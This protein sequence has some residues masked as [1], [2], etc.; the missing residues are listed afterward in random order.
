MS[1][2]ADVDCVRSQVVGDQYG[3][4]Y[5][6]GD[7]EPRLTSFAKAIAGGGVMPDSCFV[8]GVPAP[9]VA[10]TVT[11]S[12]GT[13]AALVRGYVETF[14]TQWGEEGAPS[15]VQLVNGKV[16][17]TT[18]AL[19]ALNPAPINTST[20]SAASHAAGVVT[21]TTAST[22][23]LRAGEEVTHAGIVGMTDLN[24]SFI[25][26]EVVDSAHYK[27]LLN[28]TQTY[29]SGG[30][31]TRVAPHNISN[32]TRRIY[33]TLNGKYYFVTELPIS[34]A[35]YND[36]V[37]DAALQE[38]LPSLG[39]E[40]PPPTMKALISLPNGCNAAI[41]GY[42]ICFSEP[43]YPHA[44][45]IKY[46]Q[47]CSFEPVGIA[48]FGTSIVV[49]TKGVPHIITGS[50]PDSV[51]MEKGRSTSPCLSKRSV[52]GVGSGVIYSSPDG[53]VFENGA[54]DMA[55]DSIF[56]RDEWKLLNP[57]TI[58]C[59]THNGMLFG[60]H[61]T[62]SSLH[63]GF[64][65]NLK[66]GAFSSTSLSVTA[67]FVDPETNNLYVVTNGNLCQWDSHPYNYLSYDWKSKVFSMR[68]PVNFS[69]AMVDAD[70]SEASRI[71][72]A[73]AEDT[74]YNEAVLSTGITDGELD[75]AMLGEYM[76]DGSLLRGGAI[77]EYASLYLRLT[78][79]GDG[80]ERY[81]ENVMSKK[82]F[83]L[84][85][86]YKASLWEFQI[87]GNLPCHGVYI[88]ETAAGLRSL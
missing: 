37:L 10:P 43:W 78:I 49:G 42:D 44:W 59:V 63:S 48:S 75:A 56:S 27:V 17:T 62:N 84:P 86:G 70:F 31:W 32:M 16:D 8:L 19:T 64:A 46:R 47:P 51:S 18:W 54:G 73:V 71:N 69:A 5:W 7:N 85:S 68:R 23:Y 67:A 77:A 40:M 76:L 87:S 79:I 24:G 81:T 29:T 15:P 53:L 57:A 45:P 55:T 65:F 30:T 61:D 60:W 9:L 11:P 50:H 26:S 12:G 39:W 72:L 35:S 25:I 1:W 41:D 88:A 52:I 14:V 20:I 74:A 3:R 34:T 82:S 33:R 36:T 38:E 66:T 80:V 21:V 4:I 22:K 28:T 13:G 6:T 83:S 58:S 2:D